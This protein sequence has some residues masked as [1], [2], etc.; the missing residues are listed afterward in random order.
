MRKKNLVLNLHNYLF[1]DITII[2]ETIKQYETVLIDELDD[3]S[4]SIKNIY[5]EYCQQHDSSS[6][7]SFT[8]VQTKY[9][10]ETNYSSPLTYADVTS[11]HRIG[12]LLQRITPTIPIVSEE[13]YNPSSEHTNND[14]KIYWL[15][16]PLDGTK[17]FIQCRDEFTINIALMI[18]NQPVL[19]F[20]TVPVYHWIFYTPIEQTPRGVYMINTKKQ[21]KRWIPPISSNI[22]QLTRP[23]IVT[24]SHS[25]SSDFTKEWITSFNRWVS[26]HSVQ[27]KACGSSL[28]MLRII[29]GEC[30]IY[31]RF[32]PTMEWDTGASDALLR[33]YGIS[34]YAISKKEKDNLDS[35]SFLSMITNTR[36]ISSSSSS[37]SK[38]SYGK[39]GRRN[40]WFILSRP[41]FS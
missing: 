7:S 2:I 34:I 41:L 8:W 9:D 22:V 20:V 29:M 24:V 16:D 13:S 26:P 21:T 18:H 1:M 25:H 23:I 37:L 40:E 10:K 5:N 6:S 36:T 31:P 33:A 12:T 39:Q 4:L 15:V 3:I 19:G 28:K 14:M 35:D 27:V 38:L 11:H 30:D 32:G 17:E